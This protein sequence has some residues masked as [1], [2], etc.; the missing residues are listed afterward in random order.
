MK[1]LVCFPT[2]DVFLYQLVNLVLE[3]CLIFSK[4]LRLSKT[5]FVLGFSR[6]VWSLK[7]RALWFSY[8]R[9][10]FGIG[11]LLSQLWCPSWIFDTSLSERCFICWLVKKIITFESR[12]TCSECLLF[13]RLRDMAKSPFLFKV[14]SLLFLERKESKSRFWSDGIFF[15]LGRF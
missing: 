10:S 1:E 6:V 4:I 2:T 11:F 5:Y 8:S 7:Q 3:T 9:L 15:G 13:K 14:L 12:M